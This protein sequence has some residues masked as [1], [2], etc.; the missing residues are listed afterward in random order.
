MPLLTSTEQVSLN[1]DINQ[2]VSEALEVLEVMVFYLP[3]KRNE[4]IAGQYMHY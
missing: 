2:P 1:L 4:I 3:N